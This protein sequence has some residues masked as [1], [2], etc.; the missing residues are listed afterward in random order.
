MNVLSLTPTLPAALAARHTPPPA[1]ACERVTLARRELLDVPAPRGRR[2][3]CHHGRL[4]L[5]FEGCRADIVLEA[6]DTHR[7]RERGRLVV[8]ALRDAIV[9]LG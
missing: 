6:G 8:Q 3:T 1:A 2:V 5:T 9:E 7:C 4:W